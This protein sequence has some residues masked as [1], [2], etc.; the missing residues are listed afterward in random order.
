MQCSCTRPPLI[1]SPARFIFIFSSNDFI[2]FMPVTM[3]KRVIGPGLPA[4]SNL[5]DIAA[6]EAASWAMA[7]RAMLISSHLALSEP[8][9]HR[10]RTVRSASHI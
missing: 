2:Y 4:P 10:T 3:L 7:R 1:S 8:A 9:L 5:H 6:R